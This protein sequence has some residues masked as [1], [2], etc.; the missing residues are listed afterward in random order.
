[1]FAEGLENR[2]AR[3]KELQER[4][5]RWIE[6]NGYGFYADEPYRSRALTCATNTKGTDLETLKKLLG[7]RGYAFDNG[8]G[9][10]KGQTFRIAHMGDTRM[11]DLE[12]FLGVIDEL[13]VG[14]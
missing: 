11:E 1:M 6:K 4:V 14:L 8:Y 7:E 5:G 9:K 10:I 2:W 12:E 13:L 3:H